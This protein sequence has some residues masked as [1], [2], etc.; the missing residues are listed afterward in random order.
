MTIKRRC[1]LCNHAASDKVQLELSAKVES[2]V[3]R[4]WGGPSRSTVDL[5]EECMWTLEALG[6][7]AIAGAIEKATLEAKLAVPP[8]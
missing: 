1:D 2:W 7:A 6:A 3:T 5:C 8:Q 4:V